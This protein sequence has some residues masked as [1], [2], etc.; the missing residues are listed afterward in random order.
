MHDQARLPGVLNCG[1]GVTVCSAVDNDSDDVEP[2]A[3]DS[4]CYASS[5][6][7]PRQSPMKCLTDEHR[8]HADNCVVK[9]RCGKESPQLHGQAYMI[10]LIKDDELTKSRNVLSNR[11]P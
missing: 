2:A 7:E 8:K 5:R 1:G 10:M 11:R 6:G 9:L 4:I 3:L